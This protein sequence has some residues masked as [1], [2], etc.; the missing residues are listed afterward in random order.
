MTVTYNSGSKGQCKYWIRVC[1]NIDDWKIMQILKIRNKFRVFETN[2]LLELVQT[3]A[4]WWKRRLVHA[5]QRMSN[6]RI[7]EKE[8]KQRERWIE[9][10]KNDLKRHVR[11][12]QRLKC[13]IVWFSCGSSKLRQSLFIAQ[14]FKIS[15][16]KN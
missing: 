4:H 8:N 13:K 1:D 5:H 2:W 15:T 14:Y 12:W 9:A 7:Q 16:I 10:V 11:N 6:G 3:L